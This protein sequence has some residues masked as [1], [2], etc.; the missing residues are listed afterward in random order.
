MSLPSPQDL[1]TIRAKTD[2]AEL[3]HLINEIEGDLIPLHAEVENLMRKIRPL[4]DALF[5]ATT[6]R[7]EL[8]A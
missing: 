6:R 4:Q 3:D 2:K 7:S 5:T 1:E 8:G